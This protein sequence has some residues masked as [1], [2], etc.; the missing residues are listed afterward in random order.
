MKID[1]EKIKTSAAP[2]RRKVNGQSLEELTMSIREQGVLVPI[3]VRQMRDYYEVVFG[4]RRVE[5]ARRAGL[6]KIE[7]VVEELDELRS[8]QQA[9]T[10]NVV[11]EDM[12]P[13]EIAK[14]LQQELEST[15][16]TQEEVGKKYGMSQVTVA[17]YIRML[18]PEYKEIIDRS[19]ISRQHIKE[20][21]TGVNRNTQLAA[22]VLEKAAREELSTRQTRQVAEALSR[23]AIPEVRDEI[24]HMA[25]HSQDTADDILRSATNMVT[26]RVT[27]GSTA[28]RERTKAVA[29]HTP[30]KNLA[31]R[32]TQAAKEIFS[33]IESGGQKAREVVD[34]IKFAG[35]DEISKPIVADKVKETIKEWNFILSMMERKQ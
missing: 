20:A 17:E 35:I 16:Q 33:E 11:R 21:E 1:L 30:I 2:V 27:S 31:W 4:N 10:E 9:L 18:K 32:D 34:L 15:G 28:L 23:A 26:S 3:K 13:Y 25:I 8:H 14:A 5:A 22:E 12:T 7:A 6:T 29:T 24:K 19:I